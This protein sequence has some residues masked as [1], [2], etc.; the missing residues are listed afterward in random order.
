MC[1][2]FKTWWGPSDESKGACVLR[3]TA[4]LLQKCYMSPICHAVA[5]PLNGSVRMLFINAAMVCVTLAEPALAEGGCR[6]KGPGSRIHRAPSRSERG[7]NKKERRQL[8]Y[9]LSPH[10]Q[11]FS[12][13]NIRATAVSV[14]R[15]GEGVDG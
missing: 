10:T 14:I 15:T 12:L 8:I 13:T 3:M 6:P 4:R 1:N 11:L 5:L 9:Y 7:N 2:L